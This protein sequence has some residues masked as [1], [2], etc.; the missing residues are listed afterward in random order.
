MDENQ[1][2]LATNRLLEIIRGKGAGAAKNGEPLKKEAVAVSPSRV[3]PARVTVE[4]DRPRV[5]AQKAAE[6]VAKA[7]KPTPSSVKAGRTGGGLLDRVLAG[8][9]T[10]FNMTNDQ[11]PDIETAILVRLQTDYAGWLGLKQAEEWLKNG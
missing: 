9:D 7:E 6:P 5:V 11:S 2:E 3:A 10:I 8:E 1:R 4:S